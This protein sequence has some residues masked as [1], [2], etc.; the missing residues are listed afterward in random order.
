MYVWGDICYFLLPEE[1]L[2][3]QHIVGKSARFQEHSQHI[4]R[5]YAF[6]DLIQGI[7]PD[8]F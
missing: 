5:F 6:H 1:N 4:G 2:I 3:T 7:G 8:E